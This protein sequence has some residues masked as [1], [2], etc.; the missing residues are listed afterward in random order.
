MQRFDLLVTQAVGVAQ[1]VLLQGKV[2]AV[3]PIEPIVGAQPH[4]SLAVLEDAVH[5][6]VREAALSME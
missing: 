2:V 6:A 1:V 4:E 3:V 5:R